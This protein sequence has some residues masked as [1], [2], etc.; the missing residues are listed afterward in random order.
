[1]TTPD[2]E[3]IYR[4]A[5]SA[6]KAKDY[7]RASELLR[8]ILVIDENY[9]DVSRLL[10]QTVK[11]KRRRWYNDPR[12]WGTVG[13]VAIIAV[14]VVLAPKVSGLFTRPEPTKPT[15]IVQTTSTVRPTDIP[16]PTEIIA[17]APTS[18][19]LAWKRINMGQDFARDTIT[20]IAIDPKDPDV[21]Y[22][23][24]ENAGIYKSIDGGLSWRPAH[25]GLGATRIN[26][27]V[28]D[29][30]NPHILFA[31][32]LL[33]DVYKSTDG[34]EHWQ[35][36]NVVSQSASISQVIMDPNDRLHLLYLSD[37]IHETMDGGQTWQANIISGCP[38]DIQ[39]LIFN[40]ADSLILYASDGGGSSCD[41]GVYK[42]SDGGKAWSLVGLKS[43][44]VSSGAL[45]IDK[46][47]GNTLYASIENTPKFYSSTNGGETWQQ[48]LVYNCPVMTIHPTDS[49]T[50]Y[51]MA[52]GSLEKT[53]N[54]G[55][56]WGKIT[57]S[58][59]GKVATLSFSPQNPDILYLGRK[60]LFTSTNGGVTWAE[61][62]NGL[63]NNPVSVSL[64]TT[65]N[66]NLYALDSSCVPKGGERGYFSF[67]LLLVSSDEGKA[68]NKVMDTHCKSTLDADGV[69]QY[70]I[71][72][73]TAYR[74]KNS[75]EN[76]QQISHTG[77]IVSSI[78]AN[79]HQAGSLLVTFYSDNPSEGSIALSTDGGITWE[80]ISQ[81]NWWEVFS[82]VNWQDSPTQF[83]FDYD[84]GQVIHAVPKEGDIYRSEDGG[85]TWGTCGQPSVQ[86]YGYDSP[87]AMDPSDSS[88][89]YLATQGK[90][91]LISTDGCQTWQSSGLSDLYV[92]TVSIDPNNPGTLYA[93]TDSGAYVTFD[94]GQTW[95]QVNDGLLGATVVY[96][97][98]VDKDSNVYAATPYGIFKLESK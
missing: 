11:L 87:L 17:P 50:V 41:A 19:P 40:P 83:I 77:W 56:S 46:Q 33:D 20:A 61:I 54:G 25:N 80:S 82:Q 93:G 45:Q 92:N 94:S 81:V 98:V 57:Y 26:S 8:Q 58:G 37:Q 88:R 55:K 66:A 64:D 2:L 76:P 60:G 89:V 79:P 75:W 23:G 3:P 1:M 38:Q 7:N 67:N 51:C 42:S 68:W 47:T 53:A 43:E 6:L 65:Q 15:V 73:N 32:V 13:V 71:N 86:S 4:E 70:W 31:G 48:H 69:T 91:I 36:T 52:Q 24:T 97:V 44:K 18:I 14:G 63:G 84:S 95:G 78:A 22:A 59:S 74:S 30:S 29:P 90:G 85:K 10:A 96:S 39:N 27:L 49:K 12:L 21:L 62:S 16:I 34:G 35:K 28:I 5:Q 9:K 72:R